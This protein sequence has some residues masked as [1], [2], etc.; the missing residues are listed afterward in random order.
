MKTTVQGRKPMAGIPYATNDE[1]APARMR[2]NIDKVLNGIDVAAVTKMAKQR[3]ESK[4]S[5]RAAASQRIAK[6]V[7]DARRETM[8]DFLFAQSVLA[9]RE[10]FNPEEMGMTDPLMGMGG[11]IGMAQVG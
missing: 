4:S 5:M 3:K 1:T 7:E 2:G 8:L 6:A 10:A 9:E 11:P